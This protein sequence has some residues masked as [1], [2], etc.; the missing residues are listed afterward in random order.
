MSERSLREALPAEQDHPMQH[1]PSPFPGALGRVKITGRFRRRLLL[2]LT[3]LLSLHL[4]PNPSTIAATP[5]VAQQSGLWEDPATWGKDGPPQP[6]VTI[7]GPNSSVTIPSDVAVTLTRPPVVVLDLTIEARGTLQAADGT[8]LELHARKDIIVHGQVLGSDGDNGQPA[9]GVYL[10]SLEGNIMVNGRVRGGHAGRSPGPG[11]W[12]LLVADQGMVENWGWVYGGLGGERAGGGWVG[13][14]AAQGVVRNRGETRG[15]AGHEGGTV[16]AYA[17]TVDAA[18]GRWLGGEGNTRYGDAYLDA[19]QAVLASHRASRV[20]GQRLSLITG[21]GGII[22]VQNLETMALLA[23]EDIWLVGNTEARLYATG[24]QARF[25]PFYPLTG[26]LNVWVDPALRFLDEDLSLAALSAG[27]VVTAGPRGV[28]QPVVLHRTWQPA[29]PGEPLTWQ[30]EVRNMG[31]LSGAVRLEGTHSAGGTVR[32]TPTLISDLAPGAGELI[33][34]TV[35]LPADPTLFRDSYVRI[36]AQSETTPGWESTLTLPIAVPFEVQYYPWLGYRAAQSSQHRPPSTPPDDVRVT[37][38]WPGAT[39]GQAATDRT[40]LMVAVNGDMPVTGVDMAYWD[41]QRWVPIATPADMRNLVED[42]VWYTLWNAGVLPLPQVYVRARVWSETAQVGETVQVVPIAHRPIAQGVAVF[43][44]DGSV[45]WDAMPSVDL[46]GDISTYVW[47]LG[48]GTQATGITVTHRYAAGQYVVRLVV[49]D[50][51]GLSD[52]A[53]YVIDT[54]AQTWQEQD[55]C[56]CASVRL[57][58]DGPSPIPLPW[59][60]SE[61]QT[62]GPWNFTDQ[63]Q[64]FLRA[65]VA[66]EATLTPGSNARMCRIA[67]WGRLSW[68][69]GASPPQAWSW[70]GQSFPQDGEL[71]GTLGYTQP[72]LLLQARGERVQ[73]VLGPGWGWEPEGRGLPETAL[74]GEGVRLQGI[75]RAQISGAAGE[76]ACVWEVTVIAREGEAPQIDIQ[77][78]CPTN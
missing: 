68:Q 52:E 6:D 44:E 51:T 41:G 64:R 59:A 45:T 42:G 29:T 37:I 67:Q 2:L 74:T 7:P 54:V 3:L 30:I 53:V 8:T 23:R 78:Q 77:P 31:N 27:P 28:V 58:V 20:S 32:I 35:D 11:G 40:L 22:D 24:N 63:G 25:P 46:D 72:S 13:M 76:C 75:F 9:G 71:W 26:S 14:Y 61:R 57:R 16:F 73:W 49:T 47:D 36:V 4:T 10:H 50:R 66:V 18:D 69:T 38:T 60:A 39:Q 62:L 34:V 12:V 15:G 56:G 48:D 17:S 33:T 70:A 55:T 1:T 19:R 65:N 5:F 21:E 43:N